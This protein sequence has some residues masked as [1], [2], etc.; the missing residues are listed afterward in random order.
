[1][2]TLADPINIVKNVLAHV[3]Q[4]MNKPVAAPRPLSPP[5]LFVIDIALITSEVLRPTRYVT[6]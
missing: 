4:A 1:M 2:T 6:T 3:G 5:L